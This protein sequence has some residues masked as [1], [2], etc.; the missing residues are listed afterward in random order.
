[1]KINRNLAKFI[2]L[3][4]NHLLKQ[5]IPSPR[6]GSVSVSSGSGIAP[7]NAL[8]ALLDELQTFAKPPM[9]NEV[10]SIG[11]YFGGI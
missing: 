2:I 7:E 5:P 10:L 9:G 3:L 1:L 6:L 11:F 4:I 8:D